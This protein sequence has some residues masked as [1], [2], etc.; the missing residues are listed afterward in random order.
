MVSLLCLALDRHM[1]AANVFQ[2]LQMEGPSHRAECMHTTLLCI[3][4]Q[5]KK[6]KKTKTQFGGPKLS[7][8]GSLTALI[9][10][11]TTKY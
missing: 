9:G 6:K 2:D 3:T 10:T 11:A 4:K 1:T 8:V 5:K 7:E